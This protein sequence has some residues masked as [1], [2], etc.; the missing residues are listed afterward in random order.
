MEVYGSILIACE[1]SYNFLKNNKNILVRANLT[2]DIFK[3]K[4]FSH[5]NFYTNSCTM[6]SGTFKF[7]LF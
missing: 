5:N 2:F 1:P 6:N 3:M 4:V 7:Y